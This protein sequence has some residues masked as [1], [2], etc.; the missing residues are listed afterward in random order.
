MSI[1]VDLY[2]LNYKEF[3]DELWNLHMEYA[4]YDY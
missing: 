1:S 4:K 2:K 3:V